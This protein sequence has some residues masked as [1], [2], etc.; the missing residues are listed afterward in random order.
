MSS[1]FSGGVHHARPQ[2][3]DIIAGTGMRRPGSLA[4][5]HSRSASSA[6]VVV[7][8]VMTA[9]CS[10]LIDIYAHPCLCGHLFLVKP[11]IHRLFH[12]AQ[13]IF[14]AGAA[15]KMAGKQFSQL[16]VGVFLACL[17]NFIGCQHKTW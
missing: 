14:V 2:P 16:V 1:A 13:Y 7:E 8:N 5:L 9:F 6:K 3:A 10:L 4:F 12:C 15:A 17:Q 11:I